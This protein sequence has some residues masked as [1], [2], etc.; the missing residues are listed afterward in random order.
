MK[1]PSCG[2]AL[3]KSLLRVWNLFNSTESS[4]AIVVINLSL[5]L[6]IMEIITFVEN[7]TRILHIVMFL[8][9]MYVSIV[10]L[11]NLICYL[12]MYLSYSKATAPALSQHNY[13]ILYI[14]IVIPLV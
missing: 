10:F 8:T 14:L 3:V 12:E 11:F 4:I 2:C 7:A 9:G 1:S 6:E 13:S 5:A